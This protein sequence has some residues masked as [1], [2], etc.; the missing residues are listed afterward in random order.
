M[1]TA[2]ILCS[3][4]YFPRELPPPFSSISFGAL[5]Q[6]GWQPALGAPSQSATHNLF[7]WGSLRRQLAIPN[8]IAFLNLAREVELQW[9]NLQVIFATSPWSH[10]LPVPGLGRAVEPAHTIQSGRGARAALR[11][12]YRYLLRADISRFYHSVYTHTLEWAAHGKAYV[13]HNRALPAVQRQA[14]WGR[15]LD[16]RHRDLQDRQ[17]VGVPIGPDTSLVAAELLLARV[18]SEVQPRVQG[19]GM[20][21]VDD[22]EMAFPTLSAAEAGLA[23]LQQALSDY[24]LAVNPTKTQILELPAPLDPSWVRKLR[25]ISLR[26]EGVGQESDFIDLFDTAFELAREFPGSHSIKFAMGTIRHSACSQMNWTILQ[27]LLLQAIAVEPGVIREVLSELAKYAAHG[28]PLD[29]ARIG[30]ALALVIARHAP[31]DHGSE[32]AWALW[33]HIQLH[34]TVDPVALAAVE[35]MYDCVVALLALDAATRGLMPRPEISASGQPG[36][37]FCLFAG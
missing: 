24:E 1:T 36:A 17:S 34:I 12:G 11:A 20:R 27:S 13:K 6:T 29:R 2:P 4:G 9:P 8:P 26:P 21:Y 7:R 30:D 33:A 35:R 32:V 19:R 25:R 15:G 5:A 3:R 23:E 16:D 31:L 22:Y 10:S 28:Y 14:L 37:R 18:D